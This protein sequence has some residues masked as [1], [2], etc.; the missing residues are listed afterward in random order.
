MV[1]RPIIAGTVA[2][3]TAPHAKAQIDHD[4]AFHLDRQDGAL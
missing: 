1:T 2:L 3:P 4:L